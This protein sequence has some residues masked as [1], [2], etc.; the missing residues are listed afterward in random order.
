[1]IILTINDGKNIEQVDKLISQGKDIFVL[2]YM[3]GCGPCNATRPEWAKIGATLSHQYSSNNNLVVVEINKDYVSSV[4]HIGSIDGF[5]TMKY[6][7]DYG[8]II[9]T[10]ENSTITNKDRSLDSFVNWIESKINK[11]VSAEPISSAKNVYER[12]SKKRH[13]T[14]NVNSNK[15]IMYKKSHK[16]TKKNK[17]VKSKRI[18]NKRKPRF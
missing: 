14:N 16:R 1:M 11:V 18:K 8:K 5:P 4:K 6:I 15:R 13:A 9:E 10:Y 3:E 7:G 12:I 2:V 17:R